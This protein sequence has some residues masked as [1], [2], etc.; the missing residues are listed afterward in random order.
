MPT[1]TKVAQAP[2]HAAAQPRCS[3]AG[4]INREEPGARP[5]R[6]TRPYP[7]D[8]GDRASPRRRDACSFYGTCPSTEDA[9]APSG[10]SAREGETN[11]GARSG[12]NVKCRRGGHCM[13]GSRS[14]RSPIPRR[15]AQIKTPGSRPGGKGLRKVESNQAG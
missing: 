13:I 5:P 1:A 11:M 3:D 8:T 9:A 12:G 14:S 6:P 2:G 10:A 15:R 4:R 7:V